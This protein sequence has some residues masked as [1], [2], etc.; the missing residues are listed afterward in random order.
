MAVDVEWQLRP[1]ELTTTITVH[2]LV[3]PFPAV[4]GWH[5]WFRRR[6]DSG[7]PLELTMQ[8]SERLVRGDDHLPTGEAVPYDAADGPFDDAFRVPDGR[9]T[10]RWPG[11]LAIDIASDSDWYVVFDELASFVCVEPQ[12]GPPD[13]LRVSRG[14]VPGPSARADHDVGDARP[15]STGCCGQR[16][17]AGGSSVTVVPVLPGDPGG[18]EHAQRLDDVGDVDGNGRLAPHGRGHLGVELRPRSALELDELVGGL[19]R[20]VV[21]AQQG[22]GAGQPDAP[23]GR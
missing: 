23:V 15:V 2:A 16:W 11:V 19:V 21:G 8:A 17:A 12:S 6:L 4:V 14:R 3:E 1:R 22:L 5:P 7:G 9:A 18:V 13:G 10:V 20:V